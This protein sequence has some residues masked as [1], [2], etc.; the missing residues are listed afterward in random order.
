MVSSSYSQENGK[1]IETIQVSALRSI[2]QCLYFH[3]KAL[4]NIS[5]FNTILKQSALKKE[6]VSACL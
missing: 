2:T 3:L 5:K 4:I 1:L 6:F